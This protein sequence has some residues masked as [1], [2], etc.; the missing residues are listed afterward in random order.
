[1]L[2]HRLHGDTAPYRVDKFNAYNGNFAGTVMHY[3]GNGN[4]LAEIVME[5]RP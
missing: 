4:L 2:T 3:D 5:L 1:V